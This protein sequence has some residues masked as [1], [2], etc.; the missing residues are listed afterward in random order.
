MSDVGGEGCF[1]DTDATPPPYFELFVFG[2][3]GGLVDVDEEIKPPPPPRALRGPTLREASTG[4]LVRLNIPAATPILSK[5]YPYPVGANASSS[6]AGGTIP[7]ALWTAR[8]L[9]SGFRV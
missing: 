7:P 2:G 4:S 5:S 8:D 9:G 6:V 3:G 1:L